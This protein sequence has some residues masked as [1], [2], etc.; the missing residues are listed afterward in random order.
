MLE[1]CFTI[2]VSAGS[3]GTDSD[4]FVGFEGAGDAVPV[5][6]AWLVEPAEVVGAYLAHT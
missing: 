2:G 4:L 6:F 1:I 3:T 5:G